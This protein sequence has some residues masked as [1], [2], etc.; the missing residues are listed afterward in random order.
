MLEPHAFSQSHLEWLQAATGLTLDDL[1]GFGGS[2]S[3]TCEGKP[4]LHLPSAR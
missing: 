4:I 1:T 3:V 2:P